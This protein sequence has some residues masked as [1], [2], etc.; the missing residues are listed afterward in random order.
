MTMP[1]EDYMKMKTPV[2]RRFAPVATLAMALLVTACGGDDPD[3][4]VSSAQDYLNRQD[5]PAAIIQL[6]NA[7]KAKPDFVKARLLLGQALLATGD[8]EGAETEFKKAQDLGA[9]ADEI[10]PLLVHALLQTRQYDK[11]TK[12]YADK[13]LSDGEAQANL[14]TSV[15]IAWQRQGQADKARESLNEALKAKPDYAPALL[16]LARTSASTGDLDGAL[17]GLDKIPR[18]SSSAHEALKLRGDLLLYGKRDMAGAQAA[19]Q[20]S[21]QIKPSYKEAQAAIIELLLVQ[22]KLDE[23]EKSLQELV[24]AAP[25]RPQTL[26]LE[27]LLAFTK[28]DFKTAQEKTQNLVRLT[29]D[30]P[31]ALELAG[32]TELQLGANVQAEAML[33]K[34]LQLNPGLAMARRGL[35]TTYVRLGRLDNAMPLL[36]S[37]TQAGNVDP[38]MLA[39][40]GQVYM[41]RGEVD[42]AQRYFAR[43]SSLDPKDPVK[44]TSLALSHLAAGQGESAIGELQNIAASDEGVVAD[45]ALINTLLQQG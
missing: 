25:G 28:K 6:K 39:L 20:E 10:V 1:V 8:A 21:L 34:A 15:G 36:P 35:V 24:K 17:A 2:S 7:L 30:S 5:A 32:M 26:Y 42:R 9:P 11:V 23:A 16:E 19:Y 13:R 29:P 45:M 31:R 33:S 14:K 4:L 22:G 27:A 43:A 40:A 12:D 41:L 37:E 38:A 44:R 18:E 3:K